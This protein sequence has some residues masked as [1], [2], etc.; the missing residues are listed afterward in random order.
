MEQ[1]PHA[2]HPAFNVD[3]LADQGTDDHAHDHAQGI[4][5]TDH[6]GDADAHGTQTQ[7]KGDARGKAGADPVFEHKAQKT[8]QQDQDHIDDGGNHTGFLAFI[9]QFAKHVVL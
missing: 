7:G 8:A 5:R 3:G 2:V 4:R 1:L 6:T 9:L